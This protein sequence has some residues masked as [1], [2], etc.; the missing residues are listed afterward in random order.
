MSEAGFTLIELLVTMAILLV[1]V[2]TI[3][4][5]LISATNTE[6]DTNNRFQTQQQARLGLAKLTREIHCANVIQSVNGVAMSSWTG[7]VPGL[8]L[9]LPAGCPTG[10]AQPVTAKWCTVAE[11]NGTRY[12]LFRTT[13]TTCSA[14]T[15]VRWASA[16]VNSTP[17]SLPTAGT[18]GTQMHMPLVHIDLKVATRTNSTIGVY[19]LSNDVTALNATRSVTG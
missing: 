6:T 18:N 4:G 9:S 19:D 14:A 10:G 5:A 2:G 16:L 17:F 15:G 3:T 1:V 12:D 13:T 7:P 11:S 8:T